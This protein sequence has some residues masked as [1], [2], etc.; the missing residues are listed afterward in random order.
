MIA[1]RESKL[2]NS[3]KAPCRLFYQVCKPD[4]DLCCQL[5]K[6]KKSWAGTSGH[7]PQV[8]TCNSALVLSDWC[9]CLQQRFMREHMAV[10]LWM[11]DINTHLLGVASV[12]CAGKPVIGELQSI[13][14]SRGMTATL[15]C[16][17]DGHPA[18]SVVFR[19][20]RPPTEIIYLSGRTYVS[21]LRWINGLS[22]RLSRSVWCWC[23]WLFIEL[24][25]PKFSAVNN[26]LDRPI[27]WYQFYLN[28]FDL[29]WFNKKQIKKIKN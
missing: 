28:K 27:V 29:I 5:L 3:L 21:D 15:L 1:A 26:W 16:R 24:F 7:T 2:F 14:E 10:T 18:P 17:S 11:M 20:L 12:H 4:R 22:P 19:R 25:I 8:N 13:I 6:S 9:L 23:F